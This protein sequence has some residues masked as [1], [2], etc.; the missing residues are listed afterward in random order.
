MY[1]INIETA[2]L[3][4]IINILK[5]DNQNICLTIK[6]MY[7]A[8]N[9]ID[10]SKWLSP[11]KVNI[12]EKLLPYLKLIEQKYTTDLEEYINILTTALTTY[13]EQ[14]EMLK[15]SAKKLSSLDNIEVL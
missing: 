14:M 15:T 11:E 12:E 3:Q 9:K 10:N 13:E 1:N 6:N 4:E 2:K 7:D 8:I 5:I